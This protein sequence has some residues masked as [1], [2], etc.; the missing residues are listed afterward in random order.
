MRMPR[1]VDIHLLSV[2]HIKNKNNYQFLLFAV[3]SKQIPS[4][5]GAYNKKNSKWGQTR[6][7]TIIIKIL[8]PGNLREKT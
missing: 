5:N 4:M 3:Y 2:K 8:Q 1:K 7:N 6:P